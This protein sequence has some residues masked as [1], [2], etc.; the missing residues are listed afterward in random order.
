MAKYEKDLYTENYKISLRE[1]KQDLRGEVDR[2]QG[3][4]DSILLSD[5]YP[6]N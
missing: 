4:K 1:I 3:S 5:N 2:V 6:P